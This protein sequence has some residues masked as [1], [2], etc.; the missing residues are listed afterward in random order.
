MYIAVGMDISGVQY[1]ISST[2]LIGWNPISFSGTT[3]RLYSISYI[4]SL[5]IA[6]GYYEDSGPKQEII[7][8]SDGINWVNRRNGLD[9]GSING[10][11]YGNGLYVAVGNNMYGHLQI[12]TSNDAIDWTLRTNGLAGRNGGLSKIIYV[13]DTFIATGITAYGSFI[14]FSTDGINWRNQQVGSGRIESIVHYINNSITDKFIA[15]GDNTIVQEIYNLTSEKYYNNRLL[16]DGTNWVLTYTNLNMETI[17]TN[18]SGP[19][20]YLYLNMFN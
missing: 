10:V 1:M 14:F 5:F 8:S 6:V 20:F 9:T 3:G 17:G 19:N 12:F 11:T 7:T 2:N 4:N 15:V 13:S 18:P 16:W